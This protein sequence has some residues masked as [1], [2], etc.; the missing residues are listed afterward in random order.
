MLE[1]RGRIQRAGVAATGRGG[2]AAC[3]E[4]RGGVSDFFGGI[5]VTLRRSLGM[6]FQICFESNFHPH[7]VPTFGGLGRIAGF[8]NINELIQTPLSI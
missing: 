7:S 6:F 4:D 5:F 1:E 8:A 3:R 2:T